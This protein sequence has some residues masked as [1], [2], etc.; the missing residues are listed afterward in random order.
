MNGPRRIDA[1]HSVEREQSS[2]SHGDRLH[3]GG[4]YDHPAITIDG[5]VERF[6][7]GS[8]IWEEPEEIL[9]K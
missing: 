6:L 8:C 2:P 1:S 9:N 7:D 5:A 4:R 3:R